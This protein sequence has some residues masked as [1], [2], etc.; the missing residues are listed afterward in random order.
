[1][2]IAL[3]ILGVLLIVAGFVV[4]GWLSFYLVV[5]NLQPTP[6]SRTIAAAGFA[7]LLGGMCLLDYLAG[8]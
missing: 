3:T 2:K 4:L 5:M 6:I 7:G 8:R 1:V